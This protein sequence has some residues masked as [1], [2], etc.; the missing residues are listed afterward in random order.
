[1]FLQQ[2]HIHFH[3]FI[4]SAVIFCKVFFVLK[5][6]DNCSKIFDY[7]IRTN[8]N[9]KSKIEYSIFSY[10]KKIAHSNIFLNI[11]KTNIRMHSFVFVLAYSALPLGTLGTLGISFFAIFWMKML[12]VTT[13]LWSQSEMMDSK[14]HD[15]KQK[16]HEKF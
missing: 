8:S 15:R 16:F 6:C 1:M 3:F 13:A 10:S 2:Q 4:L 11:R 14:V 12:C 7:V 5:S 9:S